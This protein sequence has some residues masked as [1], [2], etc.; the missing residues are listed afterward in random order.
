M[1]IQVNTID[2]D[3]GQYELLDPQ[4][5]GKDASGGVENSTSAAADR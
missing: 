4:V 5:D 2:L 3:P 1:D